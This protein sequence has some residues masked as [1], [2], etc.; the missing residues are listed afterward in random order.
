[1]CCRDDHDQIELADSHDIRLTN[2]EYRF[3]A[4]EKWEPTCD[5]PDPPRPSNDYYDDEDD[6]DRMSIP[7]PVKSGH[8]IHQKMLQKFSQQYNFYELYTKFELSKDFIATLGEIPGIEIVAMPCTTRY[9]TRI[10]IGKLFVVS[11]V[12]EALIEAAEE[13]VNAHPEISGVLLNSKPINT[14]EHEKT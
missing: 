8:E 7:D 10:S 3:I 1:M 13:Y 9:R 14:S 2:R 5:D 6:D 12:K 4:L 11:E